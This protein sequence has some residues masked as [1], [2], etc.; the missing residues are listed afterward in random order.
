VVNSDITEEK[1]LQTELQQAAQLSLVG[2]LAA[3]LAH[4]IKNPLAGIQGTVDIL[5][6]RRDV[7]DPETEA[8]KA[9]R[10]EVE[11]IDGTVR[12]L[13]DRARPRALSLARTSLTELIW[14]A[15]SIARSQAVGAAARGH[16]VMIRFEPPPADI[17]L[18]L[19]EA[20]IEDA[21]LNLIINAIE[22]IKGEGKVSVSVRRG[23]GETEAEFEEEAVIEVADNGSGI[24]EEDLTR[25]FH[26]FFTTTK[27]G[28]GLG[29]PAV[30]R[31]V[32]AHGGRVEVESTGGKGS[33]FSLHL[34][35]MQ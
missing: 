23:A 9:I 7:N 5:I 3:G 22:A 19:D 2:E 18:V 31:I 10:H 8:L 33:T 6:R 1:R 16:Q 28:T 30:R 26:P 15:V 13:L 32:R 25:I 17:E 21:V 4:E 14:R 11:R 12:A 24:S 29:L 20:Q 34:P 35:I 27:G